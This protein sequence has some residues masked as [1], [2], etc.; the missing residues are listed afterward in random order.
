MPCPT[1]KQH[2]PSPF[3]ILLQHWGARG[4][5]QGMRQLLCTYAGCS[6]WF[7][8]HGS[9]LPQVHLLGYNRGFG[10]TGHITPKGVPSRND[11]SVWK[12]QTISNHLPN[13][14]CCRCNSTHCNNK[15]KLEQDGDCQS[16]FESKLPFNY[17]H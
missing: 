6:G 2:L 5:P 13:P 16:V 12:D 7:S 1:W 17:C 15:W 14:E 9:G 8:F 4:K 10:S 3:W 11:P